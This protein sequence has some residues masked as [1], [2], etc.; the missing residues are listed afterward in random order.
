MLISL[1][2][3]A[4]GL[5]ALC[6]FSLVVACTPARA[7][8]AAQTLITPED[9]SSLPHDQL[10][11]RVSTSPAIAAAIGNPVL[12]T[13]P[14]LETLAG[15][16]RRLYVFNNPSAPEA[17]QVLAEARMLLSRACDAG[18]MR[19]CRDFGKIL[20]DDPKTAVEAIPVLNTSCESG[21]LLA[22]GDLSRAY[23]QGTGVGKDKAKALEYMDRV[24]QQPAR[25]PCAYAA[26]AFAELDTREAL[27]RLTEGCEAG[28]VF[29]CHWG[30]S[31]G[32]KSND[33]TERV[34]ALRQFDKG[35]A[36]G[37]GASCQ[38]VLRSTYAGHGTSENLE[39]AVRTI[40]GFCRRGDIDSCYRMMNVYSAP[41]N[42]LLVPDPVKV[43]EYTT[44]GCGFGDPE[45]CRWM[46]EALE[47]GNG[48]PKSIE[49]AGKIYR[50]LCDQGVR[51]MCQEAARVDVALST[52]AGKAK[53]ES[54]KRAVVDRACEMGDGEACRGIAWWHVLG[55]EGRVKDIALAET[56]FVAGCDK[57][58]SISC[59]DIGSLKDWAE[60][61]FAE[62]KTAARGYYKRACDLGDPLGCKLHEE[63]QRAAR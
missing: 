7:D 18:Q 55:E 12:A 38:G 17:R 24:C 14:D 29:A 60:F 44:L 15:L 48:T 63:S 26:E 52:V 25:M 33:P 41:D 1:R 62:N 56:H 35:C 32:S 53:P 10:I 22:C 4:S 28:T 42:A 9:W 23:S 6:A 8:E 54:V 16:A 46:A 59:I 50:S 58:A 2:S 30:A 31:I 43:F 5:A 37:L 47:A 13:T 57:G 3:L 20:V 40:D 34:L 51:Q 11:P 19:A 36:L 27:R 39:L 49:E 21:N 45:S 61:G